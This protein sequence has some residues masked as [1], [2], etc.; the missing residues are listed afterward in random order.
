M[1][2]QFY[3]EIDAQIERV[4]CRN[5]SDFVDFSFYCLTEQA[6]QQRKDSIEKHKR[7]HVC[8]VTALRR[9]A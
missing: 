4:V 9:V 6:E 1:N 7:E 2:N 5:C 8:E 3:S